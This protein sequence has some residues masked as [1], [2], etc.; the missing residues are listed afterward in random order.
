LLDLRL[1]RFSH[2]ER[3]LIIASCRQRLTKT[4]SWILDYHTGKTDWSV[5]IT[6]RADDADTAD[7]FTEVLRG[8]EKLLWM[9]NASKSK[10]LKRV[11]VD[12]AIASGCCRNSLIGLILSEE[13][14]SLINRISWHSFNQHSFQKIMEQEERKTEA[15]HILE[16][17]IIPPP[18]RKK[19]RKLKF[20]LVGVALLIVLIAVIFYYFL[21]IA[22]YESTDDAFIDG[23]VA[24]I[25]P[26]VPGQVARLMVMDNQEVK[27]GDVLVEIDPRDYQASLS[28]ARADLAAASSQSSQSRAQVNV[29]E[30][31]VAQAQAAVTSAEAEVQ[32]AN[33][34]L[35]RYQSVESR[36]VSKSAIDLAQAQARTATANLESARSQVK[37]A[38][39][40]ATLSEAG[41]ET[42]TATSQQAEAKL[43]QAELNLSYTKII[44]PMD[45]RVTARTVQA[46]NYVQPG[47]AL[48]ALVPKD[49]WVTAN[50]KETQLT[51]MKPGQP[52]EL[53]MDAYPNRKFKGRVNSLQAGTGARFSLLPPENAV[54]NY[55]KVVQR[56]PVKI[57]FDEALPTNLDIAPGMS[58][59]P[60]VKVK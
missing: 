6:R 58:V 30:A 52:V 7:L 43:Q 56:V 34:D 11:A 36:A 47:Q 18:P 51:C 38:E 53:R 25:S 24:L 48:L 16:K 41:V 29:S 33:D 2:N 32:R 4:G 21:F 35:K 22:P 19:G 14:T 31:K 44:A 26:R 15:T 17:E 50:F 27:A 55:I 10:D 20:L 59:V 5:E 60:K 46:G 45:G 40:E 3:D 42:A 13:R 28:Q 23:Y 1:T 37:A 49:V 39:A 54:G 9:V 57:I 8:V 12:L